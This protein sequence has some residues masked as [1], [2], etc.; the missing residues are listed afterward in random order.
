VITLELNDEKSSACDCCGGTT[1]TL[2]RWV[3][4]DDSAFA[5]YLARFSDTHPDRTIAVL[6]SIGGWGTDNASGR[7]SVALEMRVLESGPA[8]MVVDAATSPWADES[9]LGQML[10][11]PTALAH[12]AIKDVFAITDR[13]VLD[14]P[15]LRAFLQRAHAN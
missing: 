13:M 1:T 6:L 3:Y 5:L 14:D 12:R 10:D 11:R 8:V 9:F 15:P 7:F 4:K 2:S